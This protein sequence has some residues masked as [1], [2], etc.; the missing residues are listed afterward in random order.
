VF[1]RTKHPSKPHKNGEC[2]P[3]LLLQGHTSEGYGLAWNPHQQV[4]QLDVG[5]LSLIEF[6]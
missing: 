5:L 6:A 4:M 2:T 1:D 3:D